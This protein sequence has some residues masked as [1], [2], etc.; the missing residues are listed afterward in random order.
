MDDNYK[1]LFSTVLHSKIK[2]QVIG[3]VF[4]RVMYN[5]TLLISI[6]SYDNVEFVMEISNFSEKILNG[7]STDYA[8]Y[9]VLEKYK[10]FV[11]NRIMKK[12]FV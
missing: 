10:K 4:T 8:V 12:Y 3:K 9:E 5:D 7:W 11:T 6:T 1:Y 2:E